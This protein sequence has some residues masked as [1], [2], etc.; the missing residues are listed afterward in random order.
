[1]LAISDGIS[2]RFY[3]KVNTKTAPSTVSTV[4]FYTRKLV[5]VKLYTLSG[6]HYRSPIF[7]GQFEISAGIEREKS[8]ENERYAIIPPALFCAA[9]LNEY[10]FHAPMQI[11]F[12]SRTEFVFSPNNCSLS[13]YHIASLNV[14]KNITNNDRFLF[15]RDAPVRPLNLV[16]ALTYCH[17]CLHVSGWI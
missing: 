5:R 9:P 11:A 3:V 6:L 13:S 15:L 1:M 17:I 4:S 16:V 12:S 10:C 2:I 14:F 8:V 7:T